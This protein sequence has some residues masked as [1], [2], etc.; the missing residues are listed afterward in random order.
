MSWSITHPA[1]VKFDTYT[2][3]QKRIYR[4]YA[5][6]MIR[7][8]RREPCDHAKNEKLVENTCRRT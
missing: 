6:R 1:A 3:F 7:L 8:E 4:F 5:C 2:P